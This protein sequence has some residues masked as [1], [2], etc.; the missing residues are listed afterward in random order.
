MDIEY[1]NW[2][3]QDGVDGFSTAALADREVKSTANENF[4]VAQISHDASERSTDLATASGERD[5]DSATN[6]NLR[7]NP[8][9]SAASSDRGTKRTE[10][11]TA[12]GVLEA[13]LDAADVAWT[14]AEAGFLQTLDTEMSDARAGLLTGASD[15]RDTFSTNLKTTRESLSDTMSTE[16]SNLRAAVGSEL[17]DADSTIS[18]RYTKISTDA[19]ADRETKSTEAANG[20]T[21]RETDE[22]TDSIA[23]SNNAKTNDANHGWDDRSTAAEIE[24]SRLSNIIEADKVKYNGFMLPTAF[25]TLTDLSNALAT[26]DAG[27]EEVLSNSLSTKEK[28]L[29]ALSTADAQELEATHLA[30]FAQMG[31]MIRILA[32]T[33]GVDFGTLSTAATKHDDATGRAFTHL[34]IDG[35]FITNEI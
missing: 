19:V 22:E 4:M 11:D 29:D 12:R 28:E 24:F 1:G 25:A 14:T 15:Q 13:N 5:S 16:H 31:D 7:A 32:N 35:S 27:A 23:K 34:A 10:A 33:I 8:L 26:G 21:T 2:E 20:R 6:N 3:G 30:N 18:K 17:F 9:S